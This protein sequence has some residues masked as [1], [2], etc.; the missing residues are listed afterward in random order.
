MLQLPMRKRRSRSATRLRHSIFGRR[1]SSKSESVDSESSQWT[2]SSASTEGT[3]T[4]EHEHELSGHRYD[5][6]YDQLEH[7]SFPN[8]HAGDIPDYPELWTDNVRDRLFSHAPMTRAECQASDALQDTTSTPSARRCSNIGRTVHP[9]NS[10]LSGAELRVI[11]SGAPHFLLEKGNRSHWF[12]HVVFPWDDSTRIQNLQDRKPLH[13]ASFT[14]CTLHAHLPAFLERRKTPGGSQDLAE[15]ETNKY[16]AFDIGVF[17]V[18]N[19]LSSRAKERGCVGFRHFMEL[20]ISPKLKNKSDIPPGTTPMEINANILYAPLS[21]DDEPYSCCRPGSRYSRAQLIKGG[22]PAWRRLG[23]R[24]CSPK[25][26]AQRL[27]TLCD[28]RDQMVFKAKPINLFDIESIAKLHQGL[29]STFLFPLPKEVHGDAFKHTSIK[30]QIDTLVKVLAVKDAWIDFSQIEWRIRAGQILWECPPHHDGIIKDQYPEGS[31][32]KINAERNW[33]LIQLLLAAELVLRLDAALKV[34]IIGRSRGIA[35]TQKDIY[36]INDMRNDQVDWAIICCRR[37][38]ESLT[39]KYA[40]TDGRLEP[41]LPP[42]YPQERPPSRIRQILTRG[43]VKEKRMQLAQCQQPANTQIVWDCITR[44]RF[45]KKQLEGLFA[46]MNV[47]QWP[48]AEEIK[49]QLEIK[50]NTIS[51]D[52]AAM[53]RTLSTPLVTDELTGDDAPRQRLS[54]YENSD[55]SHLLLLLPPSQN[56]NVSTST[57]CFGGWISRSWL[58]GFILPGEA[59]NDMLISTLLE[60]DTHALRILGPVANLYGGFIYKGRSW[61]SKNCVVSRIVSCLEGSTT[62]MGWVSCLVV[63]QDEQGKDHTDKWVEVVLMDDVRDLTVPRIYKTTQVLLDS[64]PLG[65]GGEL[66]PEQF[67]MPMDDDSRSDSH[68]IRQTSVMFDNITLSRC[69]RDDPSKMLPFRALAHAFFTITVSPQSKPRKVLFPLSKNSLFISSFPCLPPRGWAAHSTN[70][71]ADP[72]SSSEY[73]RHFQPPVPDDE[74]TYNWTL[75]P[76]SPDTESFNSHVQQ[77]NSFRVP[78][79][80]LHASFYPYEYIPITSLPS[81]TEFP[82]NRMETC[83]KPTSGLGRREPSQPEERRRHRRRRPV[84]YIIDARGSKHK[85]AFVRAWCTAVCTDAVIARVGRT[86]LACSIREA[87]AVDVNVVI[88]VGSV[89]RATCW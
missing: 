48:D 65:P 27:E 87:R 4:T 51:S 53:I 42:D 73:H 52:P 70:H 2:D 62:C 28:L 83:E 31:D 71:N 43:K 25:Q 89:A 15:L 13:H 22:P 67:S 63:P 59:V 33:L 64:S 9:R 30:T 54:A 44:P 8:H 61:W 7:D 26:V 39:I 38:F 55:T 10:P 68:H 60:N 66:T 34:G 29:F 69:E 58:S 23:V 75:G 18:P 56:H 16:P 47:I 19:M 14:L 72:E 37:A 85:E 11:F 86:C 35:I 45:F 3:D 1:R 80:P 12:P 84:T 76:E 50:Y 88:R 5:G 32:I 46:F 79:H 17:E 49:C 57:T 81:I 24:N 78:G 6:H 40:P 77:T 36:H 20:P 41:A 82:P 21:G 74:D